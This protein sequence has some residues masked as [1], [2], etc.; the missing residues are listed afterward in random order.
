V[1]LASEVGTV[2]A[3]RRLS[4]SGPKPIAQRGA[5]QSPETDRKRN[6]KRLTLIG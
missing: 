5:E 6:H 3:Q 2:L 1:V 4:L